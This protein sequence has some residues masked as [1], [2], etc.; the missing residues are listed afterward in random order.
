MKKI[1]ILGLMFF[2]IF[3][4]LFA[5]ENKDK[6]ENISFSWQ[7]YYN[8]K[9]K[10]K[11][12]FI[13]L[14]PLFFNSNFLLNN[15]VYNSQNNQIIQL[16]SQENNFGLVNI[17]MYISSALFF[18]WIPMIPDDYVPDLKYK[19]TWKQQEEM[20]KFYK[21]IYPNNSY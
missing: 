15:Y 8:Y 14:N 19:D 11:I 21:R 2:I 9:N 7:L 18:G 13:I 3:S 20:E 16:N 4:Q 6:F 5:D 17:L 1:A 10:Q 12:D